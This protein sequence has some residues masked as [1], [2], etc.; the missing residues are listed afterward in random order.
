[1]FTGLIEDIGTV[2]KMERRGEGGL[3]TISHSSVL[4]DLQLGDSVS[5]DGVCLTI[6]HLHTQVFSVEASAETV[7]K[8][9]LGK[10]KP[11][12]KVN[13]ERALR[14]S[15]R[16]GGHL[17]TGHVDEIAKIGEISTEGSS[18]KIV[19]QINQKSA[20]Y[21]VEK[22]SVTI[23]GISLTVNEVRDKHFSVNLIPY[24]GSHTTL[25]SRKVG[26]EVNIETD[27]LGK[28]IEKLMAR[29]SGKKVDTAFLSEHGFL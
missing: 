14:L 18:K 6:T 1:M 24:T 2:V 22:G 20:R 27:I 5:V 8:T 23:D 9:T 21:L 26:D 25:L 11:Q 17:V 7:G 10:R 16:L 13:L 28:Y 3:I 12:Q 4:D 15:D 19:F 29:E